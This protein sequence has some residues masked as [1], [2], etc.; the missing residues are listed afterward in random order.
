MNADDLAYHLN[1]TRMASVGH[2]VE[3]NYSDGSMITVSAARDESTHYLNGALGNLV[4][5]NIPR[6]WPFGIIAI[7][8]EV[9]A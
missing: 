7:W 9:D 4:P 8:H 6:I 1:L 2:A 3:L 5:M